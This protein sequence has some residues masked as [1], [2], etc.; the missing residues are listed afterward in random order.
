PAPAQTAGA[1]V[2]LDES[3]QTAVATALRGPATL[4]VG[5]PGSG[6]TTV[7]REVAVRA[8]ASGTEPSRVLVLAAT[9][10][11]AARLRDEVAAAAGRTIGAPMVRTA[12]SA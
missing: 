3:Q 7:A 11:S 12:A 9:R 2:V 6:K 4:V 8:I 5:A 10:R 1:A